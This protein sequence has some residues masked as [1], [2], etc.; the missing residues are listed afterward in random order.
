MERRPLAKVMFACGVDLD[1]VDVLEVVL[2]RVFDG[3]DVAPLA[4]EL[5]ERGVERRRLAGAG[6]PA[7]EYHAEG[8]AEHLRVALQGLGQEPQLLQGDQGERLVQHSQHHHLAV[9]AVGGGDAEVD[10]F[11]FDADGELAVLRAPALGDVHAGEHLQSRDQ[12]RVNA[13]G[14]RLHLVEKAV[15]AIADAQVG[16]LGLQVDVRGAVADGLAR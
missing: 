5:V 13:Q 2:D 12:R 10:V 3:D 1:L 7:D 11:A 9:G 8:L 6:G 4:V 14:E 15:D 16:L